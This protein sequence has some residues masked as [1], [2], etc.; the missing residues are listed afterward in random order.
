MKTATIY[1]HYALAIIPFGVS[2]AK[3]WSEKPDFSHN[4]DIGYELTITI[5]DGA[6]LTTNECG[7]VLLDAPKEK[8]YIPLYYSGTANRIEG[9]YGEP[10]N[11]VHILAKIEI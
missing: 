2:R 7:D 11:G 5:P 3:C 10:V 1:T 9:R 4:D 8:F 6:K